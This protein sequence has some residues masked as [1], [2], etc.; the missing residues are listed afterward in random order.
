MEREN[1]RYNENSFEDLS[2]IFDDFFKNKSEADTS[3][4]NN[5]YTTIKI[6]KDE[7]LNGCTKEIVVKRINQDNKIENSKMKVKIPQ[8]I[9]DGINIILKAEGNYLEDTKSRSNLVITVK[10]A[11]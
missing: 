8:G 4:P 7:S 11:K 1:K 5:I 9:K 3:S 10:V 2:H 6:K